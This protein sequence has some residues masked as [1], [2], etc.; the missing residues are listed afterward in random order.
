MTDAISTKGTQLQVEDTP[1]SGTFTTIAE[2]KSFD[3]PNRTNPD[4]DASSF[5]STEMEFIAGLSSP[6]EL[7]ATLNHIS[8]NAMHQ[9]VEDD[10]VDGTVRNYKLVFTSTQSRAFAAKVSAFSLGGGTNAVL[11]SKVTFKISG[12]ITRTDP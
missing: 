11:E 6:G 4:L 2:V 3:G 8:D 7:Q 1:S 5:D 10:V 9:R 12:A